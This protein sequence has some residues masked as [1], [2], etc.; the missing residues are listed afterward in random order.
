M[1][2]SRFS[3]SWLYLPYGT[4]VQILTQKVLLDERPRFSALLAALRRDSML[5]LYHLMYNFDILMRTDPVGIG[6]R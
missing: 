5:E 3:D 2:E 6:S 4:K 1:Y